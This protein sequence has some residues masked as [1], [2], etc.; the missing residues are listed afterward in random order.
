MGP[1]FLLSLCARS[2]ALPSDGRPM[3]KAGAAGRCLPSQGG[4]DQ[5]LSLGEERGPSEVPGRGSEG[6]SWAGKPGNEGKWGRR[7]DAVRVKFME[8][9]GPW[10]TLSSTQVL[11]PP[12]FIQPKSLLDEILH[13]QRRQLAAS[14]SKRCNSGSSAWAL[15]HI[16]SPEVGDPPRHGSSGVLPEARR[17]L[18]QLLPSTGASE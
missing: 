2:T 10:P 14:H 13:Q 4:Q 12:L 5:L 8:E 17:F 9:A 3:V 11:G 15:P 1:F 6:Q 7:N 18:S 16:A